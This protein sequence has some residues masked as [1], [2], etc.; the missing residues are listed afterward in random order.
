MKGIRSIWFI[1]ML[2]CVL[3]IAG[4][5]KSIFADNIFDDSQ[6]IQYSQVQYSDN[7]LFQRI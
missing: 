7:E 2:V 3:F 4:S 5:S 1:N 6:T